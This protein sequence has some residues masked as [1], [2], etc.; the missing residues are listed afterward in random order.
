MFSPVFQ[1]LFRP[2]LTLGCSGCCYPALSPRFILSVVAAH[3]A[4]PDAMQMA[5][6]R[7]KAKAEEEA[8]AAA[9]ED[10]AA[11][12]ATAGATAAG[13]EGRGSERRL[14]IR[15]RFCDDFFE[16]CA[17]RRGIKQ[18]Y[19]YDQAE[20]KRGRIGSCVLLYRKACTRCLGIAEH[21]RQAPS[22]G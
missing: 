14:A 4:G 10:G 2:Y 16:D 19:I 12:S 5:E 9:A 1:S 15:T 11:Q 22:D 7:R 8:A 13:G 20:I 3:Q 18:V 6:D 21:V 17:G